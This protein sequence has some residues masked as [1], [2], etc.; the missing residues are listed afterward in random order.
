MNEMKVH[1][2]DNKKNIMYLVLYTTN[3]ISA[4]KKT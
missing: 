1:L 2:K 4:E 3:K